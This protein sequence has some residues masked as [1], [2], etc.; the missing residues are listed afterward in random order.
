MDREA[1][2][3]DLKRDEGWRSNVY[4]DT[5]GF[6]TIG[7]GFLVHEGKGDGLPKFIG[8]I[9]LAHKVETLE[10][11][12]RRAIPGFDDHPDTVQRALV[13]MAYQMGLNGLLGFKK[14]ISLIR[15]Q[16]YIEAADEALNSKW[17]NQTPKR[18]RRV[19][20]MIRAGDL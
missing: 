6:D 3:E 17:A 19:A 5:E 2:I 7:Y 4:Q 15:Q 9:W 12:V 1:A 13:Y 16:R 8:E 20:G 14:T 11:D 10:R 18:A